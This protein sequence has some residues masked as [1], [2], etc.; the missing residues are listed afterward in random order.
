MSNAVSSLNF[1][2]K[3]WSLVILLQKVVEMNLIILYI[4]TPLKGAL[5][6]L[7]LMLISERQSLLNGS[8]NK[9]YLR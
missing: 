9:T 4:K 8:K 7:W 1:F 2:L 3:G 6:V 5:G